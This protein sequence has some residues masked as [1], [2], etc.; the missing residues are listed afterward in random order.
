[1]LRPLVVLAMFTLCSCSNGALPLSEWNG[2]GLNCTA[3]EEPDG[4]IPRLAC[5][6]LL[7]DEPTEDDTRK[8]SVCFFADKLVVTA[9]RGTVTASPG[10]R[11]TRTSTLI[12]TAPID[13]AYCAKPSFEVTELDTELT[14]TDGKTTAS[15]RVGAA[16]SVPLKADKTSTSI[17]LQETIELRRVDDGRFDVPILKDPTWQFGGGTE[18]SDKVVPIIPT[19]DAPRGMQTVRLQHRATSPAPETTFF[20]R[21]QIEWWV[22]SKITVTVLP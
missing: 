10:G 19:S 14:L 21:T 16:P 2:G 7:P 3:F 22:M 1:M 9:S 11:A 15:I 20:T 13:V 17:T 8:G 6:L 5:Q 12:P 18:V 4:T